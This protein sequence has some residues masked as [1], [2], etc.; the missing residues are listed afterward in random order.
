VLQS[1]SYT[2]IFQCEGADFWA[3]GCGGRF[4]GSGSG[5]LP[6]IDWAIGAEQYFGF[7]TFFEVN[8]CLIG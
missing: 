4:G 7:L 8:C 2:L 1:V 6:T 5:W 3:V